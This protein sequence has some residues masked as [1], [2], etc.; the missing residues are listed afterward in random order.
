MWIDDI[1]P[2]EVTRPFVPPPG[3][4]GAAHPK[5]RTPTC[6]TSP[7]RNY[8]DSPA[9]SD[10]D[11]DSSDSD[12]DFFYPDDLLG[13]ELLPPRL[14]RAVLEDGLIHSE[15]NAIAGLQIRMEKLKRFTATQMENWERNNASDRGTFS[16]FICFPAPLPLILLPTNFPHLSGDLAAFREARRKKS[17]EVRPLQIVTADKAVAHSLLLALEPGENSKSRHKKKNKERIKAST[18]AARQSI[19][20]GFPSSPRKRKHSNL[21]V[22][23]AL[24]SVEESFS[25]GVRSPFDGVVMNGG[26]KRRK[27]DA[28]ISA[29]SLF[30]TPPPPAPSS[31]R[32]RM[33]SMKS[34]TRA[35]AMK[36][37]TISASLHSNS[38]KSPFQSSHPHSPTR[39]SPLLVPHLPVDPSQ[40]ATI[41]TTSTSFSVPP[42]AALEDP[43]DPTSSTAPCSRLSLQE[44]SVY[45]QGLVTPSRPV[46]AAHWQDWQGGEEEESNFVEFGFAGLDREL[47]I[48]DPDGGASDEEEEEI[49]VASLPGT[50]LSDSDDEQDT[51]WEEVTLYPRSLTSVAEEDD[52][53]VHDDFED[54]LRWT[55]DQRTDFPIRRSPPLP[56]P[57]TTPPSSPSAYPVSSERSLP[58]CVAPELTIRPLTPLLGV[59]NVNPPSP[60]VQYPPQPNVPDRSL[61]G[62]SSSGIACPIPVRPLLHSTASSRL[63]TLVAKHETKVGRLE[64]PCSTSIPPSLVDTSSK[65]ATS[66]GVGTSKKS[67]IGNQD[68]QGQEMRG[69]AAG[70]GEALIH[71]LGG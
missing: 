10:I 17:P 1:D 66:L 42:P 71:L 22:L 37:S 13:E 2:W 23:K 34:K 41:A 16:T 69:E 11:D 14:P 70:Q 19:N 5:K 40:I 29:P 60:P 57:S 49:G 56:K 38:P 26:S 30:A 63:A 6:P 51:S 65:D 46:V 43:A 18:L 27:L 21:V 67:E 44:L 3:T 59:A 9:A 36:P 15:L 55:R 58:L 45:R 33:G 39:S 8:S 4:T 61:G 54:V 53:Q 48:L 12:S 32:R 25:K 7:L 68:H 35:K 20:A 28:T 52:I 50:Y 64:D 47:D 24:S 31:A 62:H